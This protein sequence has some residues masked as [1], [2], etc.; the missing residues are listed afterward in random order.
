MDFYKDNNHTTN[1]I[2]D[3]KKNTRSTASNSSTL[4]EENNWMYED[5]INCQRILKN[6]ENSKTCSETN[7]KCSK[8]SDEDDEYTSCDEENIALLNKFYNVCDP[9][10]T[11]TIFNNLPNSDREF[12]KNTNDNRMTETDND[13][14]KHND[15]YYRNYQELGKNFDDKQEWSD[16]EENESD[17]TFTEQSNLKTDPAK[18]Y[19]LNSQGR[20]VP[21]GWLSEGTNNSNKDGDVK[22]NY[23]ESY[24]DADDCEKNEDASSLVASKPRFD[25]SY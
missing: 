6:I 11:E 21:D 1:R 3:S 15:E 19:Y 8:N 2:N 17:K 24:L 13:Y 20:F 14:C 23:L 9:F 16:C 12:A 5:M 4:V 18:I 7:R 10:L 25:F 22:C